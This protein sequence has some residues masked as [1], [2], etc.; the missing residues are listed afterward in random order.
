MNP[1]TRLN[2]KVVGDWPTLPKNFNR[3]ENTMQYMTDKML[4]RFISNMATWLTN[5]QVSRS[6]VE[7]EIIG[8]KA[9]P[10]LQKHLTP[11]Y[12]EREILRKEYL[13]F[14]QLQ[15]TVK[16][17][18]LNQSTLQQMEKVVTKMLYSSQQGKNWAYEDYI[19]NR[20]DPYYRNRTKEAKKKLARLVE[21]QQAIRKQKS[22]TKY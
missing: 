12:N 4:Q 9:I 10:Y 17:G 19:D 13:K 11:W 18:V 20:Y 3:K 14:A 6:E 1:L 15:K 5:I 7:D 8:C 21:L 16:I 2:I 22:V